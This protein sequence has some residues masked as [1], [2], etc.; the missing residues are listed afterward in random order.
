MF[1]D[2]NPH[3]QQITDTHNDDDLDDLDSELARTTS[4]SCDDYC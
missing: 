1:D 4:S 2:N 3:V